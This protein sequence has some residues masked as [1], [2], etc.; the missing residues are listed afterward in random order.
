MVGCDGGDAVVT[1]RLKLWLIIGALVSA[2]VAVWG[3]KQ[4]LAGAFD[5]VIRSLGA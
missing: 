1:V 3:A 5:P 4:V 2:N